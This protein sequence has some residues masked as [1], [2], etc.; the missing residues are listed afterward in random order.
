MRVSVVFST[1]NSPAWLQKVLWGYEFQ[2]HRDFEVV[3]ADDGSG[4]DTAEML[5]R[6]R[7]E[8]GLEI[9]HVWHEDMG[10]RKCRILNQAILQASN[11]YIVFSDGDKLASLNEILHRLVL[12]RTAQL[13]EQYNR[14]NQVRAIVLDMPLLVEVGWEKRCDKL[15]FV[16]CERKLRVDR[17]KKKGVFNENQFKI[18]ENFQISLDN[19]ASIADNIIII[20][21]NSG[22]AALAKQVA[23]IFT[24]VVDNG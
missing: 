22:F 3:V 6:M 15:I 1:F 9:R 24:Y 19:K 4:P 10:F 23:D 12:A 18:R 5:D 20:D 7:I 8:T 21:N 16:G 2:T 14:E 17:M 11:D 13:I